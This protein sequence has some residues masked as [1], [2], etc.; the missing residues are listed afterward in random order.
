MDL[1]AQ[2]CPA[3]RNLEE[4]GWVLVSQLSDLSSRLIGLA[5]SDHRAFM[6]AK[7]SCDEKRVQLTE[8]HHELQTHRAKHGC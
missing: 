6:A 7:A 3:R 4:R 2:Y 8:S 1:G 5:G